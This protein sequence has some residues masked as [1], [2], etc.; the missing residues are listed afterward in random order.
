MIIRVEAG[1]VPPY[2]QIRAQI[3]DMIDAGVLE[4]GRRLPPIRQLAVDLGLAPGTV[5][6]AYNE[7]ERSGRVSQQP[8]RGTIVG[9]TIEALGSRD[10]KRQLAEA[11]AAFALR[12][13]Q[14]GADASLALDLA[15]KAMND[16][17]S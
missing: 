16:P 7:L 15:R 2:E 9:G 14:L 6:R 8:R 5:A 17:A 4:A 13:R 3:A 11:A 10:R 1:P 12:A